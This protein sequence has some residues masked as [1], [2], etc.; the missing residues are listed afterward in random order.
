MKVTRTFTI[1]LACA[2]AA[3]AGGLWLG[4][5]PEDLPGPVRDTFVSENRDHR[6]EILDTIEDNYYK[7]VDKEKLQRESLKGMVRALGDRFSQYLTPNEAKQLE[8]SVSGEFEGVGMSV[9]QD[10]RALRVVNVFEKTPAFDAG[11]RKGDLITEVNGR[12]IAG[13]A[14]EVAT[15]R[16]KGPPGT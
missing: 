7:R 14:S 9:Q 3:L 16:I 8:E 2:L 15:A 12:S 1:A 10:K 11:I 6:A 4:G 13:V 5:H